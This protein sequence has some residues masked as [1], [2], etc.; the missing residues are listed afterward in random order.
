MSAQQQPADDASVTAS[1]T[2]AVVDALYEAYD[3]GD[4]EGMLAL[5]ADNVSVRF[6]GQ[7]DLSGIQETA[8]F[9][10]FASGLL[11]DLDFRIERKIIDGEWAAVIWEESAT[12][13]SGEPWENHGVDVIR[14]AEGR[15][16]VLN[17]NNDV[18]LVA[19]HFPRFS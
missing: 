11:K 4:T 8:R 16:S 1:A 2:R 14:V 3:R 5:L 9:F 12:T 17:E 6:L 13:A 7:A 19:R 10:A 15:I 18:R